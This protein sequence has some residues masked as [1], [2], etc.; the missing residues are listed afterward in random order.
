M[1]VSVIIPTY[2]RADLLERAL[3]SA[4]GQTHRPIEVVVVDDGSTD[5]TPEV[6]RRFDS[7]VRYVHSSHGGC[8]RAK[9]R[10][11]Q[12]ATGELV[13]IL[14]DDD[15]LLPE[16]VERQVEYLRRHPD[17]GLCATGAFFLDEIDGSLRPYR[18]PALRPDTQALQLL[19]A[20]PFVQ[21]SVMVRRRCHELL[22]DYRSEAGE[23]YD[24]WLRT[25]TRFELGVVTDLLTVHHRHG[26]QMTSPDNNRRQHG[27]VGGVLAEFLDRTG[28]D[29]LV[30]G[31]TAEDVRDTVAAILVE[32][33][34]PEL[35]RR[36]ISSG[37]CPTA[38]FWEA[39]LHLRRRETA[40][41]RRRM[42]GLPASG[43]PEGGGD[44][45]AAVADLD[46]PADDDPETVARL[47]HGW[48][49]V[50]RAQLARFD[51]AA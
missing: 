14:D 10:G 30:T 26:A 33:R 46:A 50:Y 15:E 34:Y 25:A 51:L 39:V 21:T 42:A 20:C 36:V 23:D 45:A 6:V 22:G 13:T 40:L 48:R 11:L 49:Q 2:N 8:G 9:N 37:S 32:R 28:L 4:L 19:V 3:V 17:A 1:K 7:G 47:R 31:A 35:V 27:A 5:H 18:P 24:F 41:A 12:V 38:G 44:L 43:V 16:K 29:G